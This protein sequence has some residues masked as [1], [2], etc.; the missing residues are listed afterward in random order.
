MLKL[1]DIP[2][3]SELSDADLQVV[4]AC[5]READFAA[6]SKTNFSNIETVMSLL[7]VQETDIQRVSIE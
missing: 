4:D 6:G 2:L 1:R 7:N 3:F 5:A